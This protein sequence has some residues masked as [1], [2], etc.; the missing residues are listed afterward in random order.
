MSWN[1]GKVIHKAPFR[2]PSLYSGSQL[3]AFA[4]FEK[5][6]FSLEKLQMLIEGKDEGKSL[7]IQVSNTHTLHDNLIHTITASKV[8]RD[9]EEGTV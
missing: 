5:E 9:L 2:N 7:Q 8:I 4:I 3:L 6:E 1:G